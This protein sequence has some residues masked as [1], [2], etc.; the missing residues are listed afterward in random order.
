MS[1]SSELDTDPS[2]FYH[3]FNSL[4]IPKVDPDSVKTLERPITIAEL[5]QAAFS[6]QMGKCPGL[7]DF[8]FPVEFYRKFFDK[9]APIQI[10]MFNESFMSSKLPPTLMQASISQIF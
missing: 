10:D 7:P 2:A 8:G 1:L 3:F 9:L 6:I 4:H 5:R